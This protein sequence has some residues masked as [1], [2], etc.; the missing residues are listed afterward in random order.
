MRLTLNT[1]QEIGADAAREL[2]KHSGVVSLPAVESLSAEAAKELV[3]PNGTLLSLRGLSDLSPEVARAMTGC[4]RTWLELGINDLPADIAA[5]LAACRGS[6]SF[7][8]LKSLSMESAEALQAH[9]GQFAALDFGRAIITQQVA[10]TLLGHEGPL[11]LSDADRLEPGVEDVFARHKASVNVMLVEIHSVPLARKLFCKN[12]SASSSVCR[13]RTMSPE[14]AA[15]YVRCQPGY[16][17]SL[18]TLPADTAREFAK[19]TQDI[20][21][22]ALTQLTPEVATALTDRQPAVYLRGLKTLD[23]PDAVAVAEALAST[24]A[25]VYMPFL[26]RVSDAALAALRKKATI[27]IPPDEK[28][29]IVPSAP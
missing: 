1:V 5:I 12:M 16:L 29:T 15:E 19:D 25:P 24:P 21:L 27:T 17:I 14:I 20:D 13:L 22:P 10:E 4:G 18:D 8:N 3:T 9:S 6:L 11:G 28:L 26:E 23:G 7:P 2:A